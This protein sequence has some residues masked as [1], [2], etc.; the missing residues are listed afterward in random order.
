M[1]KTGG[2]WEAASAVC[3]MFFLISVNPAGAFHVPDTGITECYDADGNRLFPCPGP[4]EAYYGQDGNLL[5]NG[6]SFTDNGDGTLTDNITG[7]L[8][9]KAADGNS[10]TWNEADDYC[11]GLNS[12]NLGGHSSGWRLPALI[13]LHSITDLSVG[14]GAAI[15]PVFTGT[16]A[17]AYWT[18]TEDPDNNANA[19]ILNFGT[20]EDDIVAKSAANYARCVWTEVEP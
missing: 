4:G 12:M 11:R 19:W 14:T 17:A 16:E 7:L 20:T 5:H 3:L 9:Q 15:S 6:M 10:R 8:W 18:S 13:E 2:F 1:K